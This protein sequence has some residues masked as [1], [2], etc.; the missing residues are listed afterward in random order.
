MY[1]FAHLL[2]CTFALFSVSLTHDKQSSPCTRHIHVLSPECK[3]ASALAVL[4]G[5]KLIVL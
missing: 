3:L 2:I 1:H 5:E 4:S